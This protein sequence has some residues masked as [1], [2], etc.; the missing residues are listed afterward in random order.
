MAKQQVWNVY[1][2]NPV[3]VKRLNDYQQ[4]LVQYM[5]ITGNLT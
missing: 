5:H 4:K 1:K 3:K 2:S